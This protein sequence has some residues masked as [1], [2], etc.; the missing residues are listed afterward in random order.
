VN[1]AQQQ[2]AWVAALFAPAAGRNTHQ[3]TDIFDINNIA[4]NAIIGSTFAQ[5]D[6]G[7]LVY[8]A[9]GLEMARKALAGT[10]PVMQQL[11][12]DD[13]F[14]ALAAALWQAHPPRRGDLAQWGGELA[15]FVR[16]SPQLAEEAYLPDVARAEW[17]LHQRATAPDEA[18]NQASFQLLIT[19][20]PA[21]VKLCITK[22]CECL[23]SAWP[24]PAIWLA[25]Q[26]ATDLERPGF[27]LVGELLH[28]QVA[29]TA[30]IW[31]DG[32]RPRLREVLPGEAGF[33]AVLQQGQSLDVA[34]QGTP[35]FDF[36]AW[37]PQAV[38]TGLL[39]GIEILPG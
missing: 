27:E 39:L 1:L 13:S 2:Q 3:K 6:R 4:N 29:Q 23:P 15:E 28:Q 20:D 22:T 36:A 21:V 14:S 24:L 33:L 19:S 37:L 18:R 16:Q 30:L 5:N 31:R 11:I 17:A 35:E 32:H 25:H 10:Y 34:L 12:G 8:R 7:F 9:N 38:Q 26:S